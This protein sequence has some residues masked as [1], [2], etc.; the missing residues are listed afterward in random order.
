[1]ESMWLSDDV[2]NLNPVIE[3][4]Y[5]YHMNS[6]FTVYYCMRNSCYLV[7]S[8]KYFQTWILYWKENI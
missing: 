3:C 5:E 8:R 7:T 2:N 4:P 6:C 1:M